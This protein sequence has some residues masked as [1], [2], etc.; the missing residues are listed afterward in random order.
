MTTESKTC[1][2]CGAKI[3]PGRQRG[4]YCSRCEVVSCSDC[5]RKMI[6]RVAAEYGDHSLELRIDLL[7]GKCGANT[8]LTDLWSD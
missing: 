3:E 1:D 8:H 4:T 6:Q 5:S 7:C 2:L